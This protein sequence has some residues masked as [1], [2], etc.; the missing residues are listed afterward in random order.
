[1]AHASNLIRF[2]LNQ[3][4]ILPKYLFLFTQSQQYK[5]WIKNNA[6]FGTQPSINA[7]EYSNLPILIPPLPEQQ[8][9]ANI[10]GVWDNAIEKVSALISLYEKYLSFYTILL[11]FGAFKINDKKINHRMNGRWYNIPN[12]W[13]YLRIKD[14]ARERSEFNINNNNYV[15]LSC[16]KYHGFIQSLE[17]FKR[18]IFSNNLTNYKLIY[19]DDFGFP[20]NHIEEGSIGVQNLMDKAIVSPIYTVFS[21][22]TNQALPEFIFYLLKTKTYIQIF[23]ALTSSSVNRR[24]KLRWSDFSNIEICL[25][26]I[27]EQKMISNVLNNYKSLIN[28]LYLYKKH[29]NL[30]NRD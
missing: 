4:I 23:R 11:I 30:K 29:Y 5:N 2:S 3:K 10:L 26:S 28:G 12:D 16:T 15:V 19:R 25:P 18:Q 6:Q 17:Y 21:C 22:D 7:E 27:A 8:K 24:G 9:I 14:I 1:M 20:S 13:K